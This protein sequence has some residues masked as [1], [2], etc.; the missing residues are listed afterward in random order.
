MKEK[1]PRPEQVLP[2]HHPD[3][4]EPQKQQQQ[5]ANVTKPVSRRG[6]LTR[7]G[8]IAAA[9]VAVDTLGFARLRVG[10][11]AA[12]AAIGPEKPKKRRESCL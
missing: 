1:D 4:E 7:V 5:K 10:T 11:T 8:G 2:D 9:S 12:E 3:V 6:F